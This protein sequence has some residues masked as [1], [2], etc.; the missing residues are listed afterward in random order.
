[1]HLAAPVFLHFCTALAAALALYFL[2]LYRL[3]SM[4][5]N[6]ESSTTMSDLRLGFVHFLP[7]GVVIFGYGAVFGALAVSSG[8]TVSEACLM[9]L[10]IF[11]GASQF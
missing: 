3:F 9:S 2:N 6:P 1:M 5:N 7:V 8:L 10:T 4:K 11:A